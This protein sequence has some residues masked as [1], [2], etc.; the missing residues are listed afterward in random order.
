ME[1]IDITYKILVNEETG[2]R[3]YL[4]QDEPWTFVDPSNVKIGDIVY[5]DPNGLERNG[6]VANIRDEDFIYY[7]VYFGSNMEPEEIA[8]FQVY[9]VVKGDKDGEASQTD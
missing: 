2:E 6:I 3:T 4:L 8:M 7:D 1:A 5:F 9:K